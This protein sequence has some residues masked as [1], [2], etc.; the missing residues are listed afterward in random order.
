MI[1]AVILAGGRG[2]R[3]R[4]YTISLPKPL[5]PIGDKPILEIIIGQLAAQRIEHITLAV[6]H[7][8]QILQAY[9]G[10]FA[11]EFWRAGIPSLVEPGAVGRGRDGHKPAR[12]IGHISPTPAFEQT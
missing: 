11:I 5:M 8:A 12:W 7:Q 4:P 10:G 9:C 3:L 6:S 1:R 2:T